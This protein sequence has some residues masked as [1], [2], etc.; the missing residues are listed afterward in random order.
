MTSAPGRPSQPKA[1][2]AGFSA[3]PNASARKKAGKRPGRPEGTASTVREDILDAAEDVFSNLGYAG[4]TLREVS[5]K[6][7][8]T[9]AL[10]NYYFGSK[11]GLF[12]EV[13]MRRAAPIGQ[14]RIERLVAL[15]AQGGSLTVE[16]IVHAFLLPILQLRSSTQGRAFLR[17]HA[18]LHTEP[19][20]LS[21]ELRKNAYD[22]STRLYIDAMREAMPHLSQ[23]D[24]HWRMT[25]MIGTYLY[26]F[27]DTHRM[28][29]L[30][31][32]EYDPAD[33]D[34]LIRQIVGFIVGG[35]EHANDT[36]LAASPL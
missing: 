17:L 14:E 19:P 16:R 5:E 8:V 4:T 18:R 6:A 7:R 24:I 34:V 30:I 25:L 23:L 20:H 32:Q 11:F 9:Q 36:A 28:E 3:S 29:D 12:S 13:F 15:R 35:I 31:S 2:T 33:V 27:S 26:A 1:N 22:E 21:Y 10:I